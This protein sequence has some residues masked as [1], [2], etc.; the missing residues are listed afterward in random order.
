MRLII[1]DALDEPEYNAIKEGASDQDYLIRLEDQLRTLFENDHEPLVEFRLNILSWMVRSNA[2]QIRLAVRPTGMYH[3]KIGVL[4]DKFGDCIVFQ[5]SAN[6]TPY[7]MRPD[8]NFES[9]AVYP[10]WKKEI[11]E[12]YGEYYKAGFERL[13]NGDVKNTYVID[14]PSEA[15][16][17]IRQHYQGEVH[18]E[19]NE[20]KLLLQSLQP[21][22]DDGT[23]R[24]P[25][26]LHDKPYQLKNH[27]TEAIQKW[28]DASF[29]GIFALATGAGKT[30]AALHAAVLVYKARIKEG[31]RKTCLI[32]AVPYQTLADQW[33]DVAKLFNFSVIQCYRDRNLWEQKLSRHITNFNLFDKHTHLAIVVVHKT[34]MSDHF[35]NLLQHVS[36]KEILFVGDECHHNQTH[37]DKLPKAGMKIGLSATP[38]S[39]REDERRTILTTYFGDIVAQYTI[40]DAIN[41][42]V[43]S[44]YEYHCHFC[45]MN[46]EEAEEYQVLDKEIA[47]YWAIRE[48]GGPINE[49]YFQIRIARRARLLGS[50]ESKFDKLRELV[51]GIPKTTHNLFYCGDGSTDFEEQEGQ[52]RGETEVKD[53]TRVSLIL[54]EAGWYTSK[55]TAR[56]TFSQ[57]RVI[58]QNFL[59]GDINAMVAIRVLDE[60]IDIPDCSQAFLLASSQNERQYV[61]RRG[62]VLRQSSK[63]SHS[64]IHDFI[65]LPNP[66]YNDESARK[67]VRSELIR[68]IEFYRVARNSVVIEEMAV[69]LANRWRVDLTEISEEA[70]TYR[71]GIE[72]NG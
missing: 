58:L 4:T 40:E 5:G 46:S 68:M 3:E 31:N 30:I 37:I 49:T 54:D 42:G 6:E 56:E 23:P 13:W 55:F 72:S 62:R 19:G 61:Q 15:Y 35:Q 18:P 25:D 50:V 39:R 16:E 7:A 67:L 29:N 12:T 63:G 48:A 24:I 22:V 17:L 14:L 8:F 47:R 64:T 21:T 53:I 11:F 51:S 59:N 32:I 45:E 70:Q 10:S 20:L 65:V 52:D 57:R 33:T 9:I 60:G 1:G 2:L 28:N 44:Q 36:S 66:A 69:D 38:W 26:T 27:Q 43:L 71:E 41:D 34:L